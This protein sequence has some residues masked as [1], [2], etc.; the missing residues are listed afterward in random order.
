MDRARVAALGYALDGPVP[1]GGRFSGVVRI[2]QVIYTSGTH[3]R[4]EL[5]DVLDERVASRLLNEV[6]WPHADQ[7]S[8]PVDR[9]QSSVDAL[10]P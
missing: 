4:T 2:V 1:V 9:L 5:I 7:L 8:V 6:R 10:V 3:C